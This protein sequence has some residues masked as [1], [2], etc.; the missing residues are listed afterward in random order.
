MLYAVCSKC[1]FLRAFATRAQHAEMP[2]TCPACASELVIQDQAERFEPTY[3]G[4]VSRSLHGTP[5]LD[6][7]I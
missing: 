6:A 4:R 7:R 3:V 1:D 2:D 5:A